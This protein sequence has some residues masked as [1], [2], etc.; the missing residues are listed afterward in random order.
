M[1]DGLLGPVQLLRKHLPWPLPWPPY[2]PTTSANPFPACPPRPRPTNAP[3]HL[4]ARTAPCNPSAPPAM[5][6]PMYPRTRQLPPTHPPTAPTSSGA[7]DPRNLRPSRHNDIGQGICVVQ[8]YMLSFSSSL[9]ARSKLGTTTPDVIW[10]LRQNAKY[11]GIGAFQL[12][13]GRLPTLL[14]KCEFYWHPPSGQFE[15]SFLE[16]ILNLS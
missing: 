4:N 6:P 14:T 8:A 11:A 16:W 10:D 15:S 1:A 9:T 7:T 13:A 2:L 12:S 3:T 5:H